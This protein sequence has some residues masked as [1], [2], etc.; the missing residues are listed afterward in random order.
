MILL[1]WSAADRPWLPNSA[2]IG[3]PPEPRIGSDWAELLPLQIP[4]PIYPL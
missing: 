1:G 3:V 2:A 4:E